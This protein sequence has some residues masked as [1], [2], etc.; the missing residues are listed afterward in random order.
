MKTLRTV[1]MFA[2]AIMAFFMGA[3]FSTGQEVL[4]YYVAWGREMFLIIALIFGILLWSSYSF[5]YVA[6]KHPFKTN[7]EI[8]HFYCGK[9]L[10]TFYDYFSVVFCY[11][12]YIFMIAAAGTTANQQFG[13]PPY[14]VS[15]VISA[16]VLV[17]VSLGL[18]KITSI[19][20]FIGKITLVAVIAV[21]V[22]TILR[23]YHSIPE[24]YAAINSGNLFGMTKSM[25]I[26]PVA[27]A[28]NYMGT[29]IIWF[30]TFISM[31]VSN[32][33]NQRNEIKK[34]IILASVLIAICVSCSVF[35]MLSVV[36]KVGSSSIPN[37]VLAEE[38][39]KPFAY[40]F[41]VVITMGTYTASTP[42]M[43]TCVSRFSTEKSLKAK[44]LTS[45]LSV[46][47]LVI[48]LFVP[49]RTLVNYILNIGGYLTYVLY[50]MIL[51]TDFKVFSERFH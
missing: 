3:A 47:A 49:Y 16:V 39:Y 42:L 8:F 27:N 38:I 23:N 29:V 14:V 1:L 22:I 17:T 40:V 43:W 28:M 41:A 15:I 4:M 10:G 37:L 35:A 48:T 36:E 7:S 21:S 25:A 26:N 30:I 45:V 13:I 18:K 2:G 33:Y 50:A 5:A 34:G 31:L 51:I 44:V 46:C 24:N 9:V 6:S 12:C 19:L 32:N 11:A 20:G